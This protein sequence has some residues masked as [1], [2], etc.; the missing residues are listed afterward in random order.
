[1]SRYGLRPSMKGSIPGF[2]DGNLL[3]YRHPP[4]ISLSLVHC[5][6]LRPP[7]VS[8]HLVNSVD[9]VSINGINLIGIGIFYVRAL[10][11]PPVSRRSHSRSCSP[12]FWLSLSSNSDSG[13]RRSLKLRGATALC[14]LNI[15]Y[16]GIN[17]THSSIECCQ[18]MA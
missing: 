18:E 5:I 10:A 1:M 2:P 4:Y 13:S 14:F 17:L 12:P 16:L 6:M 15:M 9:I 11:L 7:Y 3:C 8:P